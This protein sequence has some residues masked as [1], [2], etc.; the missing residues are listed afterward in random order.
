MFT[1]SARR[2]D[3]DDEDD[4]DNNK[5]EATYFILFSLLFPLT[6]HFYTSTNVLHLN[7]FLCFELF[8]VWISSPIFSGHNII[9]IIFSN[10]KKTL[11][12][13]SI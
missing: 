2:D 5:T 8:A 10:K 6:S 11:L 13:N 9:I 4:D 12:E 7:Q 3:D 1:L